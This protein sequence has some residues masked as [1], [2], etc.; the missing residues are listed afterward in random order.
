MIA[1]SGL[2]LLTLAAAGFLLT[3]VANLGPATFRQRLFPLSRAGLSAG[4]T[5]VLMAAACLFY[6]LLTDDFSVKYVAFNANTGLEWGYK[7]AAFWAGHEGSF[8]LWLVMT[9]TASASMRRMAPDSAA[10]ERG[11]GLAAGVVLFALTLFLV[12]VSDP[13]ERLLPEVPTEGRDLNPILQSP[14]MIFH[15]PL[16][17]AGYAGLAALFAAACGVLAEG[18]LTAYAKRLMKRLTLLTWVFLTAGNALGSWWAYTE[19][20]WGGWWFWD[21]VEN[22]SFIPWLVTTALLHAFFVKDVSPRFVVL[23]SFVGFALSLLGAF[24]VRSGIVQSVHTFAVD[25]ARGA[26][27]LALFVVL[28]VPAVLFYVERAGQFKATQTKAS[29]ADWGIWFGVYLCLA[30]AASVLV[31]TLYP[32]FFEVMGWGTLSVGVPYFNAFFAP[33][34]VTA[35]FLAGY[36]QTAGTSGVKRAAAACVSVAGGALATFLFSGTSPVWVFLGTTAGLW[37][38]TTLVFA[39]RRGWRK[40]ALVAHAGLAVSIFGVTGITNFESEALVRMGPGL[41]KPV[42]DLI[43]VYDETKDVETRSYRAKEAQILVMNEKE[44]V[45]Y[46]LKPQRQVYKVNGQTMSAAGLHQGLFR[47]VY[48]SMGNPLGDGEYLVRLSVKPLATW[49]WGGAFLM[50]LGGIGAFLRRKEKQN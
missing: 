39:V 10:F 35:A 40:A 16:L 31:G 38:V 43:F 26:A 45:Q 49:I 2:Y 48:V 19:L 6:T 47:D 17:F 46:V 7:I 25:K 12:V 15:P 30:A 44:D 13:F 9:A 18:R 11:A 33:M 29:P 20:G 5:A 50:M 32:L 23:L 27:L 28:M 1:E 41:G 4:T 3:T 21:P 22:S 36:L 8:F 37:L 42:A 34:T 14:G 24:L